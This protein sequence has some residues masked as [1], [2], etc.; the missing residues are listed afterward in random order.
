MAYGVVRGVWCGGV[1]YAVV[2]VW[3]VGCGLCDVEFGVWWYG[4]WGVGVQ[5]A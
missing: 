5:C 3:H 1:V 2:W 4:M